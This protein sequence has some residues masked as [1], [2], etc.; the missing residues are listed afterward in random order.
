MLIRNAVDA[1]LRGYMGLTPLMWACIAQNLKAVQLLV[2]C[3]HPSVTLSMFDAQCNF[4]SSVLHYTIGALDAA[5][6]PAIIFHLTTQLREHAGRKHELFQVRDCLGL[7]VMHLAA[8]ND[9]LAKI[10]AHP[11]TLRKAA[12]Q[13]YAADKATIPLHLA[14][15]NGSAASI[16][17][18]LSMGHK[19]TK[20]G[21]G[22]KFAHKFNSPVR[23][24]TALDLALL[25]KHKQCAK[26]LVSNGCHFQALSGVKATEFA[27][28]MLLEC[29]HDAFDGIMR[30][31]REN[32]LRVDNA[33]LRLISELRYGPPGICTFHMSGY[34]AFP[35]FMWECLDCKVKLCNKCKDICPCIPKVEENN[36][37]AAATSKIVRS[38]KKQHNL[39]SLGYTEHLYCHCERRT[40]KCGASLSSV[41]QQGYNYNPEP[42]DTSAVTAR[43]YGSS[44][45]SRQPSDPTSITREQ[46]DD[47][48]SKL[49]EH[50][51]T[52]WAIMRM[53]GGWR[54]GEKRD[55][56]K[57]KHPLLRPYHQLSDSEQ[58]GNIEQ[59]RESVLTV[60]ALD[61]EIIPPP[62]ISPTRLRGPPILLEA[63]W[64]SPTTR[65]TA[66]P[67]IVTQRFSGSS[68]TSGG[69]EA[70]TGGDTPGAWNPTP[71][72]DTSEV[73]LTDDLLPLRD[74]LGRNS[75]DQWARSKMDAGFIYAPEREGQGDSSGG[76]QSHLLVPF[77]CLTKYEQE[78]NSESATE[79]L[80]CII[81]LNFKISPLQRDDEIV[82]IVNAVGS[83]DFPSVM[84]MGT[85]NRKKNPLAQDLEEDDA[86]QEQKKFDI[87][88]AKVQFFKICLWTCARDTTKL[89]PNP[90]LKP[91]LDLILNPTLNLQLDDLNSQL[92][93]LT[94]PHANRNPVSHH[95]AIAR[96]NLQM[97]ERVIKELRDL[98]APA[99][100]YA[101]DRLGHS[102]LYLAVK[103]G[104]HELV[105]LLLSH[106]EIGIIF[107]SK[108]LS[109]LS[110]AS[111]L[112]HYQLSRRLMKINYPLRSRKRNAVVVSFRP[113]SAAQTKHLVD[114]VD[115]YGYTVLHY[116]VMSGA[117]DVVHVLASQV[118]LTDGRGIDVGVKGR[119][120]SESE[121]RQVYNQTFNGG[122]K[123]INVVSV[124]GI[125]NKIKSPGLSK[126]IFPRIPKRLEKRRLSSKR[127]SLGRGETLPFTGSSGDDSLAGDETK[128]PDGN[129]RPVGT[130]KISPLGLA[131]TEW[132]IGAAEVLVAHDANPMA[133]SHINLRCLRKD[134]TPTQ[135]TI[136]KM[137]FVL[138]MACPYEYA[139]LHYYAVMVIHSN[140]LKVDR[141]QV[142][143]I[144]D[145]FTALMGKCGSIRC[146]KRL[147]LGWERRQTEKEMRKTKRRQNA[148]DSHAR[149]KQDALDIQELVQVTFVIPLHHLAWPCLTSFCNRC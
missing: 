7:T 25:S 94:N 113:N 135:E 143:L 115:S 103:N 145:Y 130:T 81:A 90:R 149:L 15:W 64:M 110:I 137:A 99:I 146:C 132:N 122:N 16:Q 51:H 104:N 98:K 106:A 44:K 134:C 97:F 131:V 50:S 141:R 127:L 80:R 5:N 35:Q 78:T 29:D 79:M 59:A 144:N 109:A 12:I 119:Q 37:E 36:A 63:D 55:N 112:G 27:H 4:G 93:P 111:I 71:T 21:D 73:M 13:M 40:C 117:R 24:H 86:A 89:I 22:H 20:D 49:A 92:N 72:I 3:E 140:D 74:K 18:L 133:L 69:V 91:M 45:G 1:N 52:T 31:A 38:K 28:L 120:R 102:A 32:K 60:L 118:V 116:A 107:D 30:F 82:E 114:E 8:K 34:K 17:R 148:R 100:V 47:L 85:P 77:N 108:G 19:S 43:F 48:V 26:L 10:G 128:I 123:Q 65:T 126:R 62:P 42:I 129:C 70:R 2:P 66:L 41:E 56:E 68:P 33:L 84:R 142:S 121:V 75:H 39:K 124:M 101:S 46:L 95:K 9:L 11:R 147:H 88:D 96:T 61:W 76:K 87:Q 125:W 138:R 139:L 67:D 136:H 14:A 105:S 6:A 57:K 58:N 83:T 23:N 53:K 54:F